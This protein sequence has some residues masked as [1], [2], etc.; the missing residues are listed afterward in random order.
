MGRINKDIYQEVTNKII[1]LMETHGS[2]WT[3]PWTAQTGGLPYNAVTKKHYNG[4]NVILLGCAGYS[5]P[6][7]ATYKQWK[8]KGCQVRRGEKGTMGIFYKAIQITDQETEEEKTIPMIRSFVLFNSAQVDGYTEEQAPEITEEERNEIADMF[9]RNTQANITHGGD[10][11]FYSPGY[12]RIQLP[13]FADFHNAEAYYGTALHE[14]AHWTGH[15]SRLDRS[16]AMASRFGTQQYAAEELV[17]E[18]AAAFMSVQLGV[19][20]EPRADHAKYINGWLSVLKNDKKA[21]SNAVS[22]AQKASDYL[23]DLQGQVEDIAA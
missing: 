11:A 18:V 20:V 19:S 14:L 12:D 7:W 13:N 9:I 22:R 8:T 23:N 21:F 1:D 17:A 16:K 3:Q 6:V 15:K 10:R 5:S 2:N 4:M